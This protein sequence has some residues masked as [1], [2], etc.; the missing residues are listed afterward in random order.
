M[1]Y[2]GRFTLQSVCKPLI[3]AIALNE[4]GR[5]VVHSYIGME[6]SGR[7]YNDMELDHNNQPHNPFVTSGS[8][9][10]IALVQKLI[11][12]ELSNAAKF[13]YIMD[14]FSRMAGGQQ[15]GFNNSV[16]LAEREHADRN[17]ALSYQLKEYSCFPGGTNIKDCL[18]LWYQC[19]S[20][21]VTAETVA[22]IA[23]TLANGGV[24]P[25]TGE[26]VLRP[27]A[28]R[29]VL[30]LLHS[31]GFYES[32]GYFAFKVGIPGKSSVAGSMMMVLPNTMGVCLWSP[33]LDSY[34][35]SCRGRHFMESLIDTFTFHRY[36]GAADT[37]CGK[38]NPTKM[39]SQSRGDTIVS[40]LY[41]AAAGDLATLKTHK[42]LGHNMN[43]SDYDGRT[44]LHLAAAEG[45]QDCVRFLL[46]KCEVEPGPRD[47]WGFT[48]LSEA[49]RAG[50]LAVS[51]LLEAWISR[52]CEDSELTLTSL[53][54]NHLLQAVTPQ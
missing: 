19:C 17:Y 46:Y 28:V 37:S 34:G 30:S 7:R 23:S 26:T 36:E 20:M 27:E 54:A 50:H 25:I 51:R 3:Y 38:N 21:E 49:E 44:P 18:D 13:D 14:Y 35:N 10:T 4:L 8:I 32:S 22:V 15:I 53:S 45:Q 2:S 9:L 41:A 1:E 33:P 48:P 40:L 31:C 43:A 16:F 24:T 42:F 52:D 29:D 12:P 11:K 6:P 5:D 47:R 39:V